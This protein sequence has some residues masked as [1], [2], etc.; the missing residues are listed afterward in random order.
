[1]IDVEV[2]GRTF[3]PRVVPFLL[4]GRSSVAPAPER[5]TEGRNNYRNGA[6]TAR[7]L[8]LEGL[9][10]SSCLPLALD[11]VTVTV[12]CRSQSLSQC[13]AKVLVTP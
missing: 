9:E 1:M 11:Y 10:A 8:R 13:A 6:R 5:C 12:F 3:L 7:P 2:A 4:G